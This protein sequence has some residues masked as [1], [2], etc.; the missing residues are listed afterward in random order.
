MGIPLHY[1]KSGSSAKIYQS[2]NMLALHDNVYAMKVRHWQVILNNILTF[3]IE[4]WLDINYPELTI[5]YLNVNMPEFIPI[6]DRK[7]TDLEKASRFVT[8]FTQLEQMLGINI[9]DE[10]ILNKL[11]PNDIISDILDTE[12]ANESPV[13]AEANAED[14]AEPENENEEDILALFESGLSKLTKPST[15]KNIKNKKSMYSKINK[16]TIDYNFKLSVDW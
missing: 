4:K 3:W 5:N 16:N 10:F 8:M 14:V 2:N 9:K 7:E 13:D 12:A 11:F 15:N 6:S 1:R